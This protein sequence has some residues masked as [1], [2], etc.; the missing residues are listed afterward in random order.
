MNTESKQLDEDIELI[1]SHITEFEC[2]NFYRNLII[3]KANSNKLEIQ[4]TFDDIFIVT[5]I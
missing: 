5:T 4:Y 3:H 2:I 1:F